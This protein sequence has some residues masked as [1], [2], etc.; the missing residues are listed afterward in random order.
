MDTTASGLKEPLKY[1]TIIHDI[2]LGKPFVVLTKVGTS[3][4]ELDPQ[5]VEELAKS[6]RSPVMGDIEVQ[7]LP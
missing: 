4:E 2:K 5:M 6:E 7:S 1:P 3:R